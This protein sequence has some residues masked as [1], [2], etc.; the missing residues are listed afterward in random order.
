[1]M[2]PMHR[3]TAKRF[4]KRRRLPAFAREYEIQFMCLAFQYV[5]AEHINRYTIHPWSRI[6]TRPKH[7]TNTGD[8]HKESIKCQA[9]RVDIL[10]ETSMESAALLGALE[11]VIKN[12]TRVN[13]TYQTKADGTM[14]CFHDEPHRHGQCV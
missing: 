2:I 7:G 1:M 9:R 10:D 11:Y 8:R 13:R 3:K 6:P 12:A 4:D 14:Q 5:M